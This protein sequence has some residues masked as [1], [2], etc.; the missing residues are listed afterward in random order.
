M[1]TLV[2]GLTLGIGFAFAG[3]FAYKNKE[4]VIDILAD[5]D[6]RKAIDIYQASIIF[7]EGGE[8]EE[9]NPEDAERFVEVIKQII[10]EEY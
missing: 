1:I 10:D 4:K 9:V 5:A 8:D 2:T 7:I 6:L 3:I